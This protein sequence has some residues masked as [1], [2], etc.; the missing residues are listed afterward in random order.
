MTPALAVGRRDRRTLIVG[1][2]ACAMIVAVGRGAP[3]LRQWE[4]ARLTAAAD[5]ERQL[6]AASAAADMATSIEDDASRTR[7]QA[8]AADSALLHGATPAAAAAALALLL[9]DRAD[10]TGLGITSESVRADT[11]FIRGFARARVRLSATADVRGLTRFLA[12]VEGSPHLLA[13]RDMTVSQPD[14]SADDDHP[15]ICGSKWLL[16]RLCGRRSRNGPREAAS[17]SLAPR[18]LDTRRRQSPRERWPRAVGFKS[19]SA[20]PIGRAIPALARAPMPAFTRGALRAAAET[21]VANDPFRL[22]NSPP[23][24]DATRTNGVRPSGPARA[25][26]P[27]LV[28]KA[29]TGGPPWQ[30]IV[31]GMPGQSGDA[32]VSPGAAFGALTVQS[33]TREE[34]IVRAP[35]TT[36]TLLLKRSAP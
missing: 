9:S 32:V 24:V 4:A 7:E 3:L 23:D 31:A 12:S 11:G 28:L 19:M 33:I 27:T 26:R 2:A 15:R 34:V 30:A 13:V 16:K 17:E 1:I 6:A 35:D 29:I 21:T 5:A 25:P 8:A 36:W 22:S 10:S 18:T 14:P 20:A